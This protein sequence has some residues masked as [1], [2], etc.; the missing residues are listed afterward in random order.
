MPVD[1]KAPDWVERSAKL[2]LKK[3]PFVEG[4]RALTSIGV[5]GSSSGD[6]PGYGGGRRP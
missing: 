6:S 5:L 4:I 1:W 3:N 2:K